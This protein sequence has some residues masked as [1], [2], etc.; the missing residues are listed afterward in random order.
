MFK[1]VAM[2]VTVGLASTGPAFARERPKMDT[3]ALAAA[4]TS[5]A[6]PASVPAEASVSDRQRYC[7]REVPTGTHIQQ[8][9]CKT[10]S[11]WMQDEGFDPTAKR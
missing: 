5:V 9:I 4:T 7:I 11:D 10:R 8:T 1:V 2:L 3:V 6:L